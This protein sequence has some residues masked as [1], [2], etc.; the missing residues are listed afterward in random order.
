MSPSG[1]AP[2]RRALSLSLLRGMDK[3]NKVNQ[4]HDYAALDTYIGL[5]L[6]LM[7]TLC[8]EAP[9]GAELKPETKEYYERDPGYQ[10]FRLYAP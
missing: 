5:V 6:E 10:E 2:A 7:H 1:P 9:A 3:D 4:I 8:W